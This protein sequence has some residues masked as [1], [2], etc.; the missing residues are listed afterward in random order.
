MHIRITVT[1]L[2]NLENKL[3]AGNIRKLLMELMLRKFR[4]PKIKNCLLEEY[5]QKALLGVRITVAIL[6]NLENKLPAGN[7][8]KLL[9]ELM[10]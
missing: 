5:N 9:M 6:R 2:K 4:L 8:R 1:I 3:P 7:I 10:L